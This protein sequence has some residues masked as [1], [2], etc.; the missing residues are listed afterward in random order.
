MAPSPL[1]LFRRRHSIAN[2]RGSGNLQ[3]SP[4]FGARIE[5]WPTPQPP[6][7]TTMTQ[8]ITPCLWLDERIEEAANYYA[9]VF[10]GRIV[11]IAHYPPGGPMPES[12]VLTVHVEML[13]TT[14]MLL[15]G[16]PE[17]KFSEAVSFYV[18]CKDQAEIDYYWDTLTADG[19][20]ESMCGW[21]KDKY[22]LS[23]QIAPEAVSRTVAGPD[24]EGARR[25]MQAMMK[26]RK[27]IVADLET[28]YAG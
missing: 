10:K 25:A 8:K 9:R 28:A 12:T 18:E 4:Y 1:V 20:E 3:R 5:W 15:N 6:E 21:L 17:F 26:M 13:G 16:G 19:G 24:R 14:F 11:D 7:E 23:W 27:M 22:G 2:R